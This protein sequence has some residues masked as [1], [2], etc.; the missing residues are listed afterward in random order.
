M[1]GLTGIQVKIGE[2]LIVIAAVFGIMFYVYNKGYDSADQKW[3]VAQAQA[4]T[5][6]QTKYNAVATKLENTKAERIVQTNTITKIVPQIV[7][8]E[9]YKNVCIDSLG[10]DVINKALRGEA[11]ETPK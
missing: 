5:E 10:M 9:I 1:F 2:Y 7:E 3:Q 4:N 11:Y 6:A 8:R